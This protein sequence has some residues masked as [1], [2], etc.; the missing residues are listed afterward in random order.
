MKSVFVILC[1]AFGSLFLA[2]VF[3]D[4]SREVAKSSGN[5]DGDLAA[6]REALATSSSSTLPK[7]VDHRDFL[8]A[9][10]PHSMFGPIAMTV[11]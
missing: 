5:L 4:A 7:F 6:T 2:S 11:T 9:D 3:A 10:G 1:A 8:A